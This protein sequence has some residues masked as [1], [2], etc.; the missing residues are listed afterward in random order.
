MEPNREIRCSF[1]S[2]VA[3]RRSE[4]IRKLQENVDLLQKLTGRL[5]S[6]K[7]LSCMKCGGRGELVFDRRT[8]EV[9]CSQCVVERDPSEV[10]D[11]SDSLMLEVC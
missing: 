4:E 9:H 6:F 7:Q 2:G 1:S 5:E 10:L 11:V 3:L 8:L